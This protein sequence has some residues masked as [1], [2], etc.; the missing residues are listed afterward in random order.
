MVFVATENFD[1]MLCNIE[2][3]SVFEKAFFSW[4]NFCF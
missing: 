2:K 1:F 3:R 4:F